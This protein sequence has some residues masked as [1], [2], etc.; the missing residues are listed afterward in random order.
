MR[1]CRAVMRSAR[2]CET[3]SCRVTK[4]V[5]P[6]ETRWS[7]RHQKPIRAYDVAPITSHANSSAGS[8][9]AVAVRRAPEAKSS[10][11]PWNRARDSRI[12]PAEK[13]STSKVTTAT[14]GTTSADSASTPRARSL[15]AMNGT[16]TSGRARATTTEIAAVTAAVDTETATAA[17]STPRS[18]SSSRVNMFPVDLAIFSPSTCRNSACSQ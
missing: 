4:A 2:I 7:S 14:V 1:C 3:R 6:A 15:P 9:S 11:S 13:T 10:M 5:S 8:V 17:R 16:E 18:T 12:S